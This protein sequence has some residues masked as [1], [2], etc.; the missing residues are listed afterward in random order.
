MIHYFSHILAHRRYA[1]KV[2]PVTDDSR[3]G[4]TRRALLDASTERFARDGYRRSSV[5]D[6]SRDAGLGGTTAYVHFA[7]KETLFFAAVDHDLTAFFGEFE[8]ALTALDPDDDVAERLLPTVLAIVDRHPLTR[9][10]LAGLEPDFTERVLETDAF[11]RL[12]EHVAA[13]LGGAQ[14]AG[15]V[16]PDVDASDLADG[17]VAVVVAV[18]MASVQIGD[19]VLGTFGPG[20]TTMLRTVLTR[21]GQ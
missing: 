15:G 10:L 19:G 20:L 6:I 12:R 14:E 7:N 8:V 9:R 21:E 2:P 4:Q 17:L 11:A 18:A 13:L 5:A 3:G 16:R 1:G